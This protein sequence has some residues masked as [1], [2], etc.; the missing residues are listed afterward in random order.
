MEHWVILGHVFKHGLNLDKSNS[1]ASY[2][3]FPMLF[4]ILK[5]PMNLGRIE[6]LKSEGEQLYEWCT[7]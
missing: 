3:S 1:Y 2:A 6:H 7:L 5:G 4:K